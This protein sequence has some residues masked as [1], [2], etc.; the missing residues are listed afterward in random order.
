MGSWLVL[1]W[2]PPKSRA[3]CSL[4]VSKRCL[5]FQWMQQKIKHPPCAVSTLHACIYVNC[6]P[7]NRFDLYHRFY[8]LKS[9]YFHVTTIE[10]P[11]HQM[12]WISSYRK[13]TRHWRRKQPIWLCTPSCGC[14]GFRP[15][16]NGFFIWPRWQVLQKF[17]LWILFFSGS[18]PSC[19]RIS[20]PHQTRNAL[21]RRQEHGNRTKNHSI[22]LIIKNWHINDLME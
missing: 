20:C 12:L 22:I 13:G 21:L 11:T 7:M 8:I 1:K 16:P 14:W 17:W 2:S 19:S 3:W 6:C 9:L 15:W 5:L 4:Y 18:T 10:F